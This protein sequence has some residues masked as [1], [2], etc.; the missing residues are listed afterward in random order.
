MDAYDYSSHQKASCSVFLKG[1]FSVFRKFLVT[2]GQGSFH[3]AWSAFVSHTSQSGYGEV[4]FIW[5]L[6]DKSTVYLTRF[7][8]VRLD[9][10]SL[11][12]SL[13]NQVQTIFAWHL[14]N[15]ASI[16][17]VPTPGT[18]LCRENMIESNL[19]SIV[20]SRIYVYYTCL[21]RKNKKPV[22]MQH[23]PITRMSLY[24]SEIS[25]GLVD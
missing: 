3:L 4:W 18:I 8:S 22:P 14:F 17:S 25:V 19:Q 16:L 9:L 13:S 11:G 2:K 20:S 5:P 23:T 1:P 24:D 12:N 21:S 7:A 10:N 6:S 15:L